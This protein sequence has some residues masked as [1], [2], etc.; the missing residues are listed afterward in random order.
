MKSIIILILLVGTAMSQTTFTT[1]AVN[2]WKILS[3]TPDSTVTYDL[4]AQYEIGA[5]SGATTQVA[6]NGQDIGVVCIVT[7]S[8][9]S[10]ADGATGQ[11]GWSM[12]STATGTTTIASSTNWGSM[13]VTSLTALTHTSDTS[14]LTGATG[15][16]CTTTNVLPVVVVDQILYWFFDITGACANI[17][18]INAAT[19][20]ARCFHKAAST[21]LV[22]ANSQTLVV[23][24]AKNV[25]IGAS[26]FAAG[27]TILAGIAYLQF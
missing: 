7:T 8:N 16:A 21:S 19:W 17:P 10:L 6:T 22:S 20:Y 13:L 24:S 14:L 26:T 23:S 4:I 2:K 11:V 12:T 25:T 9:F 27:A 5:A 1:D 3:L 15:T 18:L